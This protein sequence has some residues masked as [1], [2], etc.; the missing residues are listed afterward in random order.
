[1]ARPLLIIL[2]IILAGSGLTC[3]IYSNVIYTSKE[4][5]PLDA[6]DDGGECLKC[7]AW[8]VRATRGYWYHCDKCGADYRARFTPDREIEVD[9]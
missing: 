5:R 2:A 8:G 4:G 9:W 7:H 1:M 3:V 6:I